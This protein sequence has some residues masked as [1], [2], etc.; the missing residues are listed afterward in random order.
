MALHGTSWHFRKHGP[1]DERLVSRELP[2][3]HVGSHR[4]VEQVTVKSLKSWWSIEPNTVSAGCECDL[5]ECFLK[6]TEI[7]RKK[8]Q[9][10]K[11]M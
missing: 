7:D 4:S 10:F 9:R 6:T 11:R 8:M 3:E 1:T 2:R 5:W